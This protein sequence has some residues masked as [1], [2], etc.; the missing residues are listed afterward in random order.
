MNYTLLSSNLSSNIKTGKVMG[1]WP[2]A[3]REKMGAG[4]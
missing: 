2:V 1:S 4:S 3:K